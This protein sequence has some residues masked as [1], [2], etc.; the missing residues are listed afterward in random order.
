MQHLSQPP[1]LE[2][3]ARSLSC[4][5]HA[6]LARRRQLVRDPPR[7]FLCPGPAAAMQ[8]TMLRSL[9][10]PF[11]KPWCLP[12]NGEATSWVQ[13]SS[14]STSNGRATPGPLN[15]ALCLRQGCTL[16]SRHSPA[17]LNSFHQLANSS[18]V[19]SLQ[20]GTGRRIWPSTG[21]H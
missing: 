3:A 21:Q 6:Q 7:S 13:H 16:C 12:I 9:V 19:S 8:G 4:S 1:N 14:L 17:P 20:V 18:R 10:P 5:Q 11:H 2:H 15:R